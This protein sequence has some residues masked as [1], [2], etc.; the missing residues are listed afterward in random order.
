[1]FVSAGCV[2]ASFTWEFVWISGWWPQTYDVSTEEREFRTDK[3]FKGSLFLL[4]N[5]IA[6]KLNEK[7]CDFWI[8]FK[9]W[10]W[11]MSCS[12]RRCWKKVWQNSGTDGIKTHASQIQPFFTWKLS[13]GHD[14]L[15]FLFIMTRAIFE[16]KPHMLAK[17]ILFMNNSLL[18][19][20]IK[21]YFF[22][23]LGYSLK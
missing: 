22:L 18:W 1:M 7:Y 11:Q 19:L 13:A 16:V 14:I 21:C 23:Q 17:L 3:I 12:W 20:A 6:I 2:L 9:K 15:F 5:L 8:R 10:S 4:M